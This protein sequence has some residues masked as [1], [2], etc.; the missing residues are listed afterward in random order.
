VK[1]MA[2]ACIFLMLNYDEP[3]FVN[4]GTGTDLTIKELGLMIKRIVGFKGELVFDPSKPDGT[5]RKLQDVTRLHSLGW[6]HKTELEEGIRTVYE[7]VKDK[8]DALIAQKAK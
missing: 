1:D 3:G 7:E 8:L 5:P 4:I 2:D 6:R